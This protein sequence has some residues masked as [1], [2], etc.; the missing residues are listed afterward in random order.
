M[1]KFKTIA[2]G[3]TLIELMI[4][5]VIVG[6][7]AAVAI[8]SYQ[9]AIQKGRLT[10]AKGIMQE[11]AQNLER[12]YS[13]NNSYPDQSAFP[14]VFTTSPKSGEGAAFFNIVYAPAGDKASYT[15]TATVVS[16]YM[17]STCQVLQLKSTG[18]K[19]AANTA[20]GTPDATTG[21]ACWNS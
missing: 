8:P 14:S 4:V 20:G 2:R 10:T 5:V 18:E 21:A 16:T 13:L 19:L 1:I 11:A 15:L 12:S 9:S 7:L 6:I 3:F 17:P